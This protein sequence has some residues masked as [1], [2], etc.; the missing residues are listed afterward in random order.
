MALHNEE[1][2]AII[3]DF[4]MNPQDTGSTEVQIALL[5]SDIKK[6]TE[7]C[8]ENRKDF[9]SQ[10]GLVHKVCQRKKLLRYLGRIDAG[11]YKQLISKLGL[12]K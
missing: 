8:R 10:R 12:R 9:S 4:G 11:K 6:L 7:H 2:T 3:R 1:K 5:T